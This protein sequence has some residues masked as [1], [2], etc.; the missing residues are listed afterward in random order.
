VWLT[1]HPFS[2]L[3][4]DMKNSFVRREFRDVIFRLYVFMNGVSLSIL[5]K[6]LPWPLSGKY[7][8]VQFETGVV[9]AL[10]SAGFESIKADRGRH[11]VVSAEKD[12]AV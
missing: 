10:R 11:F 2:K 7:E 9:K 12:C 3:F 6:Q 4:K 8:S 1:L 5:R